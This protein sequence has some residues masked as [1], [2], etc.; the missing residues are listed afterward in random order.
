MGT[1]N[2]AATITGQQYACWGH[3]SVEDSAGAVLIVSSA[4]QDRHALAQMLGSHACP[5]Y[6]V[7]TIQQATQWLSN[8]HAPVIICDDTLPDGHW[9]ELWERVRRLQEP[10]AFIVSAHWTDARLW[11][12]VL[13][14]GAYDVLVKPYEKSEVTR[15]LQQACGIYKRFARRSHPVNRASA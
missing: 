14:L 15:I 9:Q 11:A 13:N 7:A 4:T 10:S 2:T 12:E 1:A 6:C 5:Q 3:L 8:H